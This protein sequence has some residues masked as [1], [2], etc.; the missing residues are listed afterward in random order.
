M[1]KCQRCGNATKKVNKSQICSCGWSYREK[2]SSAEKKIFLIMLGVTVALMGLF[3]HFFQWGQH[4]FSVLFADNSKKVQICMELKKYDCIEKAYENLYKETEDAHFLA[5]LGKLQFRREKYVE[6]RET[7]GL[8]FSKGGEGYEASYYYAHS[9]AKT[10]HIDSAIQYF[11]SIL[12]SKP[13]VVMV[14]VVESYLDVLTEH[15]RLKKA[16]EVLLW[17]KKVSKDSITMA[18]QIKNWEKK[19]KI[20]GA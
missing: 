14:T 19:F 8:Y 12:R 13:N 11:E 16:Q 9:L 17:I 5:E 20:K 18:D 15:G 2:D 3:L 1:E 4:S 7:Y 10:N 6:S